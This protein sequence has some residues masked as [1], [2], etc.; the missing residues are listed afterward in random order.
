MRQD[1][2]NIEGTIRCVL[3]QEIG[4]PIIDVEISDNEVRDAMLT[5][6]GAKK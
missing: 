2:K 5:V 3:L 4:V 1:K 6:F